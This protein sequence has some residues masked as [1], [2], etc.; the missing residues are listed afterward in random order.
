MGN[1]FNRSDEGYDL[2]GINTPPQHFLS[3]KLK[4]G[5]D[6]FRPPKPLIY[7]PTA[8]PYDTV[9]L[10]GPEIDDDAPTPKFQKEWISK[11]PLFVKQPYADDAD[12]D[13][14]PANTGQRRRKCGFQR[15]RTRTRQ[16]RRRRSQTRRKQR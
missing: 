3:G 5:P 14:N 2:T 16:N 4:P 11:Y 15:R 12:G 1:V 10:F 6:D 7:I 9:P 8:R 13:Y